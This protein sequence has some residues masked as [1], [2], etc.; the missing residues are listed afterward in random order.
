MITV[1]DK[2]ILHA[3]I[4]E[5]PPK[6]LEFVYKLFSSF[7]EDYQDRHLTPEEYKEH[8]QALNDDEWYD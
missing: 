3:V 2:T 8:L 4:D 6:E 1:T 5:L 7:I